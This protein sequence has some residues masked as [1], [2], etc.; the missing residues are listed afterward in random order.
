MCAR[1]TTVLRHKRSSQ[2]SLLPDAGRLGPVFTKAGPR[3]FCFNL[4][5]KGA[6]GQAR[7]ELT[8]SPLSPQSSCAAVLHNCCW[9]QRPQRP[10]EDGG[11]TRGR[12]PRRMGMR[13][14]GSASRCG[15]EGLVGSTPRPNIHSLPPSTPRP[16]NHVLPGGSLGRRVRWRLLQGRWIV[17]TPLR[18][19]GYHGTLLLPERKRATW[20]SQVF[21]KKLT[22]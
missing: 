10:S 15:K 6:E 13:A 5:F 7:D 14:L 9:N 20:S 12:K 3:R 16:Q 18:P 17:L 19:P 11:H 22:R 8:L 4:S 21:T 2:L 1:H